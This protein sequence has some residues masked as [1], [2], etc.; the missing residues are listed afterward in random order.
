MSQSNDQVPTSER[1]DRVRR[2]FLLFSAAGILISLGAADP[3]SLVFTSQSAAL[4][5]WTAMAL[6]IPAILYYWWA[7]EKYR[8]QTIIAA[9]TDAGALHIDQLILDVRQ[10]MG[11]SMEGA[12]EVE[13][14][15]V[16]RNVKAALA[17]RMAADEGL[18]QRSVRDHVRESEAALDLLDDKSPSTST[19]ERIEG[20]IIQGITQDIISQTK[21]VGHGAD[22][23]AASVHHA[24]KELQ[25]QYEDTQIE[26]EEIARK[27]HNID[28]RLT[29]LSSI[30]SSSA[31]IY[32]EWWEVNI[33]RA[34]AACAIFFASYNIA[35]PLADWPILSEILRPPAEEESPLPTAAPSRTEPAAARATDTAPPTPPR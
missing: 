19:Y 20:K 23:F 24:L 8:S 2:A 27:F 9:N 1:F 3:V 25:R 15:R 6:M 26:L 16:M 34:M 12:K 10:K 28:R 33:P 4:P 29:K 32:F 22:E 35:A 5:L 30:F 31:K 18:I 7:F 17:L 21:I 13:Y 11:V 14:G